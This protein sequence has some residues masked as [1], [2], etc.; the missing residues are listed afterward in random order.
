VTC[1]GTAVF[2]TPSVGAG[3][4]VMSG[5]RSRALPPQLRWRHDS[6]DDC[7]GHQLTV[8][9][10]VV[11]AGKSYDGTTAAYRSAAR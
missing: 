10:A 2:D 3:K 1:A 8:T 4:A 11:I 7:V 9:A 6:D 5:W